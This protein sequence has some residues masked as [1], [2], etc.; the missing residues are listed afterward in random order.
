MFYEKF[1]EMR[2]KHEVFS[3]GKLESFLSKRMGV[4]PEGDQL[5]S[6]KHVDLLAFKQQFLI[7]VFDED[8]RHFLFILSRN[9][10]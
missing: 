2:R 10:E 1:S 8:C 7:H 5:I 3:E 9:G 6:G 4:G